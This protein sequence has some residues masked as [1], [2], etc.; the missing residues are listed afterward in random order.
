MSTPKTIDDLTIGEARQLAAMFA[1]PVPNAPAATKPNDLVG[2]KVIVRAYRAGVHYG[3][4]VSVDGECV[5]LK[6]A[7]RLWYWV[8]ADKKGISLSDV[9]EHGLSKDSKVCA[10]VGTQVVIDACEIITTS[11]TAQK[12]IEGANAYRP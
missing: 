1:Q 3:E 9:A 10:V 11:T 4:L 12:N 7:R 6:N 8:V 5:T 2:Q